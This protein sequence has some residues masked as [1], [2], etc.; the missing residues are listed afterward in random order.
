MGTNAHVCSVNKPT[1]LANDFINNAAICN[2]CPDSH[3][4]LAPNACVCPEWSPTD[5]C[6]G[7]IA[8]YVLCTLQTLSLYHSEPP[9]NI[10]L[11][12]T[13]SDELEISWAPLLH[14]ATLYFVIFEGETHYVDPTSSLHMTFE[15]LTPYTSYN[16]CVAANTTS[17][18][19][20][21]GCATRTTLQSGCL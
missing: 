13:G 3:L 1:T 15:S 12:A 16:C 17:G 21:L 4:C 11:T 9:Q 2:D 20:R 19:T 6:S 10:T 14:G 18:P 7:N 5:D 8:I